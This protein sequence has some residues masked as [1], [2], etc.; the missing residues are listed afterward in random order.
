M[1]VV[2]SVP[3]YYK[4]LQRLAIKITSGGED[5]GYN[6]IPDRGGRKSIFDATFKAY[7]VL[8]DEQL[9]RDYDT[10]ADSADFE[11]AM[12]LV[13]DSPR[14]MTLQLVRPVAG[15]EASS[16]DDDSDL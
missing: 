1:S 15:E 12:G 11:K 8:S 6:T 16:S 5:S 3:F 9:R 10:C 14:P 4:N 7:S 2:L 13:R